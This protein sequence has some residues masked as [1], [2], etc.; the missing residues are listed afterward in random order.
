MIR[1][2]AV[3]DDITVDGLL[4]VLINLKEQGFGKNKCK[5]HDPESEDW[6]SITGFTYADD[7]NIRFY[8]DDNG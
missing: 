4:E 3:P 5:I 6:E 1:Y 2:S 7:D 8:S